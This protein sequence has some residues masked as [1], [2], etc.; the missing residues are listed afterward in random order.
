MLHHEK[1]RTSES[2]F[3]SINVRLDVSY[4]ER[5]SHFHPTGNNVRVIKALALGKPSP[6]SMIVAAYGSGKS[7]TAGAAALLVENLEEVRGRGVVSEITERVKLVDGDLGGAFEKRV[8]TGAR[9]MPIILEGHKPD[10]VGEIFSQAR[11]RMPSLRRPRNHGNDVVKILEAV[12]KKAGEEGCDRVAILWD[13]FGCH[14]EALAASGNSEDLLSVQRISEWAARKTGPSV[15]VGLILH[16]SFLHYADNLSQTAR[17]GWRKIEGRFDT[18]H[19]IED[20]REIYELVASVVGKFR[21]G[22]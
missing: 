7:L 21:G 20:S 16:Q 11:E 1:N 18:V 8:R 15:T 4:P 19:Y 14:L 13:E 12:W 10:V 17:N 6:A 9:G 3:R 2:F 22:G 5:F